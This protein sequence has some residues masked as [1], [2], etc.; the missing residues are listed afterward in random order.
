MIPKG[1][2]FS[3]CSVLNLLN[4]DSGLYLMTDLHVI[5]KYWYILPT[6]SINKYKSCISETPTVVF[7]DINQLKVV[8]SNQILFYYCFE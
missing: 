5:H 3:G 8:A 4:I 6:C 1:F 2:Q 7:T